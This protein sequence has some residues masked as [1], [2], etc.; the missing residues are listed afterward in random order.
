VVTL[1]LS[2]V[3]GT[4]RTV[5]LL[6]PSGPGDDP[7]TGPGTPQSPDADPV[8]GRVTRRLER[9]SAAQA[10]RTAIAAQ[11][12]GRRPTPRPGAEPTARHLQKVI[13]T[14]GL[15]QIDSVNVLSRS[16]YLP[17]FSRLGPYPRSLL[18]RASDR[19]PR[20]LVEY[21]A[22]EASLVPPS[23]HRLLRYR[24]AQARQ[25][26]WPSMARAAQ[27]HPE[28]VATVLEEVGRRGPITAQQLERALGHDHPRE[29]TDWG[30]N[31]SVTKRVVEYL[32]FAG[33]V[34]SAGRTQQFER[35]YAL[36]EQVLPAQVTQ[37]P[38]L[39]EADACRELV[40]IAAR[41]LGVAGFTSLADYFRLRP[42]RARPAVADLVDSG[43][44]HPVAVSGWRRPAYLHRDAKLPRRVG[45]RAL[46]SPF[47]SLVWHRER[48]EELFGFRYRIEIYTPA[49][50][51][52]HGYYVLPFLLGDRLVARVDLKADRA[53]GVLLVQAAWAEPDTGPGTPRHTEVV[54]QLGEELVQLAEWLGLD[55]VL[56]APRG[57][58]AGPLAAVLH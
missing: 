20:R 10:R 56:V 24:M 46:L 28:L 33:E 41:A 32:F 44:L 38:D 17:V 23:T 49:A 5:T 30:W 19:A 36:P 9:L 15:L 26:A 21:W 43:E 52:V 51:R 16:H 37:A 25:G 57:D 6:K 39:P 27:D 48:T 55:G 3:A 8:A 1:P 7:A 31:W 50:K 58:L 4:M 47:D 2:V 29:R 13:D 35:R 14:V 54:R 12:L 40:R 18:D 11:G 22:H 34:T 42:D 53:G 45:G